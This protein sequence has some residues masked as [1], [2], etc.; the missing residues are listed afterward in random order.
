V[1]N[2][3]TYVAIVYAALV[4]LAAL[5]VAATRRPRPK[6][7]DSSAWILEG[8]LVLRFVA[9][10]GTLLHGE[11]AAEPEAY[12]GYLIASICILPV[13]MNALSEDKGPWSSAVIAVASI[14]LTVIG[15]RLQATW[16]VHG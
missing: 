1:L 10:V 3:L 16:G 13:A 4:A 6:L 12:L 9:G 11:H 2:Q 8:V 15:V 7:L 14:A 5:V